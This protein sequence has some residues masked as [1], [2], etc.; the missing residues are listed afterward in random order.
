[1]A[2]VIYTSGSTG[3]PKGV[4]V[5][6]HGLGPLTDEVVQRYHV[7]P[8][9]RVLHGYN[10]AFDAALLEMLLAFGSGACLVVAPSDV[11]A[12]ADLHR[13]LVEQRVTHYLSTPSVL[14]TLDPSG[15]DAVRVLGVGGEALSP[16]LA[17]TWSA[18]RLMLNAYGPTE[19]TV[20]AT[21]TEVTD[22][23]TIG[24]P[25]AG[26]TATVLDSHLDPV[27][28][29]GVGE[30]YL[31]G[32]GLALGYLDAPTQT[33]ER[34]VAAPGG[35]RA[36]RTGDLVH[37]RSDGT[38]SFVGRIDRQVKIR[39]MRIEP[40][41]VE[42]AVLAL[43]NDLT[44]FVVGTD[45]KSEDV[46]LALTTTLPAYL[47]P[48][49]IVVLDALPLTANGKLD[50]S[51]LEGIG[52]DAP[53]MPAGTIAED[54]VAGVFADVLGARVVGVEQN[55]FE[56]GGDSLSATAVTA[57]I[58]A[59]FGVDVPARCSRIRL[60][61]ASPRGSRTQDR[62]GH[63]RRSCREKPV[64]GCPSRPRSSECGC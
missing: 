37:R 9:D 57:R 62:A 3:T 49:R 13:L 44:A 38:L 41:H 63:V 59:A 51:A 33:A 58:S 61:P 27:P 17:A 22:A 6:H 45:L 31:V 20:V 34:F 55:F 21:L 46:R 52:S 64:C 26:T 39:G 40:A 29:G 11:F 12:G 35:I 10:P 16:E 1:V 56:A 53:V 60:P 2:Y 4:A 5:T 19:A 30:L 15:L 54:L 43:G 23:P 28:I 24:A 7:G 36:Y 14:A 48:G 8:D 18:G 42:A 47:V 25:I 32:P 50:V